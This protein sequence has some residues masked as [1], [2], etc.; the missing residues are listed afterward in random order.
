MTATPPPR[1][2]RARRAQLNS[3]VVACVQC[4]SALL[5]GAELQR[6]ER[7]FAPRNIGVDVDLVL[8]L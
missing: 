2:K 1:V 7:V 3:L 8:R 4:V 6:K 5:V